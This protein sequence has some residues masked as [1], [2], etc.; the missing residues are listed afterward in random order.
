MINVVIADHQPIFCAG[1]ANLL[2]AEDDIRIIAQPCSPHHLFTVLERLRPHVVIL[3]SGFFAISSE[4]KRV[5][6]ATSERKIALLMTYGKMEDPEELLRFRVRGLVCRST[7]TRILLAGVRR[8]AAGGTYIQEHPGEEACTD[9]ARERVTSSLTRRELR[10]IAAVVR[11][12]KNREIAAEFG[13]S[14]QMIKNAMRTIFD[15]T[16]VSDRLEL[17]LFVYHRILFHVGASENAVAA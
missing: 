8:L 11:G 1:I 6:K 14:E 3:S 5:V 15:K 2:A 13:T 9:L 17:A 4:F 12:L 7:S 10:I 16:G